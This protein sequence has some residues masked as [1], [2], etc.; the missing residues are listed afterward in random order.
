MSFSVCVDA[1][2][3]LDWLLPSQKNETIDRLWQYWKD[4]GV[5]LLT[6][7]LFH[8]EVTSAIR[9]HVFFKRLLPEEGELVFHEYLSMSLN[10][11][12]NTSITR[13]AWELA[14]S[15]NLPRTYDMQYLA[16]AEL[17]DC[18]LWTSDRRLI[19]ALL[20][21]TKRIRWVGEDPGVK[22]N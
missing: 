8:A 20:G 15:Y 19:N 4:S 21:R 7:P 12:N 22:E 11:I 9:Q 14:R 5:R 10:T 2:V 1:S 6:P 16:V 17:M 18:E 13:I 3:A